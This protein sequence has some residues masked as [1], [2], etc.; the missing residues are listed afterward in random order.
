ME[1]TQALTVVLSRRVEH[2]E[3][4]FLIINDTF[5][6]VRVP[7]RGQHTAGEVVRLSYSI[8]G[9]YSSDLVSPAL[10]EDVRMVY[11]QNLYPPFV[12]HKAHGEARLADT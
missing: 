4:H 10:S 6:H 8:V 12:L 2:R 7:W 11:S 3:E 1:R 5:L 9:S